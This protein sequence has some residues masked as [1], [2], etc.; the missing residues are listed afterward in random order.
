MDQ[1]IV[2]LN[3]DKSQDMCSGKA[4]VALRRGKHLTCQTMNKQQTTDCLL[5]PLSKQRLTAAA[6]AYSRHT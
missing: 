3:Y 4:C 5:G 1:D 2:W 6:T